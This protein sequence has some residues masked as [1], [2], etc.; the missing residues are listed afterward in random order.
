M[1]N[2][3][4]IKKGMRFSRLTIIGPAGHIGDRRAFR[5]RCACG[6]ICVKKLIALT[7]GHAKSCGCLQRNQLGDLMRTHGRS[8]DNIYR[9]WADMRK[10]C[11][12]PNCKSYADYGGRGI[13]VCRR[14]QKFEKFLADMGERPSSRHELDRINPNGN[15]RPGN[16]RWTADSVAQQKNRRKKRDAS[17]KYR[18]V[19]FWNNQKWRARIA[20]NGKVRD[21]GLFNHEIDAARAYDA[22]ARRYPH[23]RL[24]FPKRRVKNGRYSNRSRQEGSGARKGASRGA[25][26]ATRG[27]DERQADTNAGRK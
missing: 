9:I 19:D 25:G 7:T 5:V 15:Y 2:A 24:N 20:I 4:E 27:S 18:G 17:S 1:P 14:W 22:I 6:N 21:L 8:K 12:N 16:V 13:K 26:Q 3:L 11:T 10:R 23:Y